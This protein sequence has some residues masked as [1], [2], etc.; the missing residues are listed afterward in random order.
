L[1]Q[2]LADAGYRVP[3][4]SYDNDAVVQM[5]HTSGSAADWIANL[6]IPG[7]RHI[8]VEKRFCRQSL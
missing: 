4:P 2:K 1:E 3:E 5:I 7:E 6:G 8:L